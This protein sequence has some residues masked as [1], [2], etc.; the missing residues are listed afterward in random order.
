MVIEIG[1]QE[2]LA[3]GGLVIF[4]LGVIQWL[5]AKWIKTRLEE[6]IRHE[7]GKDL[8]DYRFSIYQRE[9]AAKIANFFAKWAK[10]DAKEKDI[11]NER[12][13]LDYYEGLTRMSYELS[14]WI[15][16]EDLVKKIMARLTLSKNAPEVKQ[17]L[18]E[19]REHILGQKCKILKA[20][21]LVHWWLSG[22]DR[23]ALFKKIK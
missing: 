23:D 9:Q 6:S 15:R 13:L 20:E 12:E 1:T 21:D 16:D 14:L 2:L 18:I 7:Y 5:L 4:S 17:L 3:T 22:P 10:Y 19:I 8:E 11:L